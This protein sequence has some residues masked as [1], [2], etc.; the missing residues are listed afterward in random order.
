MLAAV[1]GDVNR[2]LAQGAAAAAPRLMTWSP[3][4]RIAKNQPVLPPTG[5]LTPAVQRLWLVG[6]Q[7]FAERGFHGTTVRDLAK[8]LDIKPASLYSLIPSKD[9][10]LADLV[11]LG[12][13]QHA[14]L[15]EQA[16]AAATGDPES[17]LRAFVHGH[18]LAHARW[19]MLAVV[20]NNELHCL[21]V[22]LA[23][24][25]LEVRSRTAGLLQEI[26]EGGAAAGVF[27]VP[28]V[29]LVTAAIGAMGMRV[30][31]WYGD[32]SPY[33]EEALASSYADLALRLVGLRRREPS[34]P[35]RR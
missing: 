25:S 28:D 1:G 19:P 32:D 31:S 16:L 27:E 21:P 29:F 26:I 9:Q 14:L 12:H 22:E 10:L 23:H 30:A 34:Q 5:P 18:V 3:A 4:G 13:Q 6:L 17:Q 33:D 35:P 11:L 8:A 24:P 2:G 20:A 15:I 7:L